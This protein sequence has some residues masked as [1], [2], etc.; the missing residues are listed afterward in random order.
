MMFCTDNRDLSHKVSSFSNKSLIMLSAGSIGTEV[1]SAETSYEQS[2]SP[3]RRGTPLTLFTK[4]V[5]LCIL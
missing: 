4:S 1:N 5:V 2:H 3:G